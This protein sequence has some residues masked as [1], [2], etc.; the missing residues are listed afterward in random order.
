MTP[1]KKSEDLKEK[2]GKEV[3]LKVLDEILD[4]I[5]EYQYSALIHRQV[6]DYWMDVKGELKKLP[7]E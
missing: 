2:F 7:A 6:F 4:A 3:A 5:K 1:K